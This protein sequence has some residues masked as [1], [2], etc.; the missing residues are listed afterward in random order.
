MITKYT[1]DDMINNIDKGHISMKFTMDKKK[2]SIDSDVNINNVMFV[3]MIEQIM[4]DIVKTNGPEALL[5]VMDDISKVFIGVLKE[6][7]D[8]SE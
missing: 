2:V 1:I 8:E 4:T 5:S 7:K 6:Y 3:A